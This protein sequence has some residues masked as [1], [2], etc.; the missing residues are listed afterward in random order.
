[1]LMLAIGTYLYLGILTVRWSEL[2]HRQWAQSSHE[3]DH[4]GSVY[5]VAFLDEVGQ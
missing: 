2:P 4:F 1:M 5:H 3:R